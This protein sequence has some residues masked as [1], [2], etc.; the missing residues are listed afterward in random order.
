MSAA[1]NT[2]DPGP[3]VDRYGADAVRWFMLS[4]SPPE[5]DLE[6][7][8][9]G[10][11]GA[12]RLVQRIWRLTEPN[13]STD[14][15]D[16]M[17]LRRL[18]HRTS[19]GIAEDIEGLQFNKAVAKIF[20]LVG[21]LEKAAPS[22][23]RRAAARTLVLLVSPMIPH[24]AETAWERLGGEGLVADAPWPQVD[25]ALLV[26]DKVTIAIQINGKLRD[27]I[28]VAKGAPKD[29]LEALAIGNAKVQAILAG[30]TPKKVIVVPDRLVNIVA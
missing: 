9:A 4:D 18:L 29:Q 25:P 24:L 13:A 3:I 26:D 2:V 17:A 16:D 5:R 28:S 30:G 6:W 27:T 22:P 20:T 12:A 7:S 11:E 14:G 15:A 1:S 10:I 8:S 21:A 23:D 19:A